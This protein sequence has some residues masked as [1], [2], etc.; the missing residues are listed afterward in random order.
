MSGSLNDQEQAIYD[1]FRSLVN[2][3]PKELE[4]WLQSDESHSVG[5]SGGVEGESV[6]HQSGRKIVQIKQTNKPDLS[7]DMLAHMKKVNGYVKRHLK[8][9][10]KGDISDS[11]WCYSL[12]NWGHDPTKDGR[13]GRCSA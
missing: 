11:R 12:K 7:D 10:P 3:A 5:V 4:D 9:R 1:E 8:Q 13:G 6:G 2:M